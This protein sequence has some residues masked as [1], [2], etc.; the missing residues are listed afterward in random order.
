M[1]ASVSVNDEMRRSL[2]TESTE[3]DNAC[4]K[5]LSEVKTE[6]ANSAELRKSK[7]HA[8]M[9]LNGMLQCNKELVD[10]AQM[11]EQVFRELQSKV[12]TDL[13]QTPGIND[14]SKRDDG[15]KNHSPTSVLGIQQ[16][17]I[18]NK[19]Q[20]TGICQE[21]HHTKA[22]IHHLESQ[23]NHILEEN[24]ILQ[25]KIK[26]EHLKVTLANQKHK[27]QILEDLLKDKQIRRHTQKAASDIVA[28]RTEKLREILRVKVSAASRTLVYISFNNQR[29]CF[30]TFTT[31]HTRRR[32]N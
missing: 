10:T 19:E 20:V 22:S 21:I 18:A 6:E 29:K 13:T 8:D 24:A 4:T 9:E 32:A 2:A 26:S 30:L 3:I 1:G 11:N 14:I 15:T 28:A 12:E 31:H 23:I 25:D 5:L 17:F 7:A 27:T 16:T